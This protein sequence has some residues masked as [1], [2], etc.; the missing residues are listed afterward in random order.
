MWDDTD[1]LVLMLQTIG[2]ANG[3]TERYQAIL[4]EISSNRG[5]LVINYPV[6]PAEE[7]L[8]RIQGCKIKSTFN[9]RSSK[10]KKYR[11]LAKI[12]KYILKKEYNIEE[13]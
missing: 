5:S 13:G 11:K 2:P 6:P 10:R 12:Y 7:L 4:N 8:Q 3:Y 9:L 1:K